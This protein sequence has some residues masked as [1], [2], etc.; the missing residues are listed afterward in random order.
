MAAGVIV[1]SARESAGVRWLPG[2]LPNVAGVT[3]D[4]ACDRNELIA[5]HDSSLG[6]VEFAASGFPRPIPGVPAE[7]NLS[8]ISFAVANVTGFLSRLL[9]A[10][11]S[12]RDVSELARRLRHDL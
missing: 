7:R 4:E 10:D 12:V 9:E 2:S 5:T 6:T 1:V 3:L 8:G 11:P